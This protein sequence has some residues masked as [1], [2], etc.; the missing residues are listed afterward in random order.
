MTL[1]RRR[2]PPKPISLRTTHF[3]NTNIDRTNDRVRA[4]LLVEILRV[5]DQTTFKPVGFHTEVVLAGIYPIEVA[6][7]I[8]YP[9]NHD[10]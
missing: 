1:A 4:V 8:K 7:E 2:L 3:T 6:V 5:E 10:A 9:W